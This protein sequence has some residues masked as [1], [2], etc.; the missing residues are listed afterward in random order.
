MTGEI[1][2]EGTA[3]GFGPI[4]SSDPASVPTPIPAVP[5]SAGGGTSA[6]ETTT[7]QTAAD[8]LPAITVPTGGGA[9][10]DMGEKFSVN[11]VSFAMSMG[12][13]CCHD[14]GTTLAAAVSSWGVRRDPS[15]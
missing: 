5:G 2:P 14:L 1:V 6:P 9:I 11:P 7:P 4:R 12:P 3:D 13:G 15:S 10:R 8:L